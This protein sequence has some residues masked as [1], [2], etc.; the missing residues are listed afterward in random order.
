MKS[1]LRSHLIEIARGELADCHDPAHDFN[2]ALNVM[3]NAGTIGTKEGADPYVT[4]AAALFHDIVHYLPND[5][6]SDDAPKQSA[7]FAESALMRLDGYPKDR[8]PAVGEAILTH[9]A[10][11]PF[12]TASLEA[13]V[14]RDADLLEATGALAIM[15]TFACAGAMNL[16]LY[17]PDDPFCAN[18]TPDRLSF[19]LDY[20][21]TCMTQVPSLLRTATARSMADQR[22]RFVRE[23]LGVV[24]SEFEQHA[25]VCGQAVAAH[26]SGQ[27]LGR[28][29]QRGTVDRATWPAESTP[30]RF[31]AAAN[32]AWA[33]G[34]EFVG[35]LKPGI[36]SSNQTIAPT[37]SR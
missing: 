35:Q 37:T 32:E 33:E 29:R 3:H 25:A 30:G 22:A 21:T 10:W 24:R 34:D 36:E 14:V 9:S 12:E 26:A 31:T 16:P 8:I 27:P 28:R 18:R 23:F 13:T 19:A 15:R 11:L 20:A 6:R 1:E 7:A 17:S 5:W 4:I 2:H